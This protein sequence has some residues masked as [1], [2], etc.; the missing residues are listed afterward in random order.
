MADVTVGFPVYNGATMIEEALR[1]LLDGTYADIAILVSDNASRDDTAAR[2]EAMAQTD[3]RITLFRQA[4]NLGPVGNF[5]FLAE[6]AATPFF[7]WRAHDDLSDPNFIATL[8]AALLDNERAVLAAPAIIT[9]KP[10]GERKR[11][12]TC[13]L[14]SGEPVTWKH[15]LSHAQA[16]WMYGLFRRPF[17]QKAVAHVHETY[18]HVWAWDY[19]ILVEALLAG[20]VVGSNDTTFIHRITAKEGVSYQFTK[21]Q[22]RRI[23]RDF[24]AV[25]VARGD[26]YGL[27]GASRASF[28]L[29]LARLTLTRVTRWS[30]LI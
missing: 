22:L 30:R 21:A 24:Y 11:P 7:L 20:G 12:F 10:K 26:A 25:G 17:L 8:R 15:G 13:H 14:T 5:R 3:S 23:A 27:S 18:P 19:Q 1:C 2:V 29:R 28:R 6:A 16:G 4:K 9:Q